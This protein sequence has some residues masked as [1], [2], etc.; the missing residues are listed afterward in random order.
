[1][2]AIPLLRAARH[3]PTRHASLVANRLTFSA[4]LEEVPLK[5]RTNALLSAF[6]GTLTRPA[7]SPLPHAPPP[8]AHGASLPVSFAHLDLGTAT[9]PKNLEHL[10]EALDA[11]KTE[12]NNLAYHA[13]QIAREKTRAEQFVQRRRDENAQRVAQGLA[14]LPE[15][16]VKRMFKIPPEPSRLESMLL[17]GQVDA[18]SK[19][20]EAASGTTLVK[21]Y[22][23]KA[24]AGAEI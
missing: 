4:I 19:A 10:V 20:L 15:D 16:D 18:Y 22:G 2:S 6:L 14:P 8:V 3:L 9:V 23:V 1:M 13:R 7:P 21:M 12:E 24:G 11:Y 17:L 5:I